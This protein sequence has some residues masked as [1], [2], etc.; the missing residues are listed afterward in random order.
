[1][2]I[3]KIDSIY[4]YSGIVSESVDT[5]LD[6]QIQNDDSLVA[7]KWLNSKEIPFIFL[8]YG[9]PKQWPAAIRPLNTWFSNVEIKDFPFI[10]YDEIDE[11]FTRTKRVL[12]GLDE[13][14]NSNLVALLKLSPKIIV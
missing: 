6:E 12:F 10:I 4:L 7:K 11:T 1:M 13:I 14:I 5:S 2:S 8:N 9:D 3:I